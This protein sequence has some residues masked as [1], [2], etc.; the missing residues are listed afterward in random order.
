MHILTHLYI[1]IGVPALLTMGH[2]DFEKC[3]KKNGKK[4]IPLRKCSIKA[5]NSK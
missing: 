5:P 4:A 1:N 2:F 3:K